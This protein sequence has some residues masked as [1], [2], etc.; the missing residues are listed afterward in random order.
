MK[1]SIML[2]RITLICLAV[3]PLFLA[4]ATGCD[5]NDPDADI[6][7]LFPESTAYKT[8]YLSLTRIGGKTA[9]QEVER[10]LG[11]KFT[12]SYEQVDVPYTLY[13]VFRNKA[14]LGYVHGVNQKGQYGGLQ[15]FLALNPQGKIIA[16]YFQKLSSKQGKLFKSKE[17]ASQF[18]GLSLRDFADL[19]IK[20]GIGTGKAAAIKNPTPDA[21]TDFLATLR[22]VKKNLI[23]MDMFVFNKK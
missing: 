2:K 23:L 18:K 14:L 9:L 19:N 4:A 15:V 17:F 13:S 20:T 22:G 7:R 8:S 1:E 16:F 10:Q 21:R 12:G 5:L 6:K 3:I 11:D